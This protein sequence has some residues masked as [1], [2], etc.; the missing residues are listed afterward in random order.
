MVGSL[1]INTTPTPD[2][3][4]TPLGDE[5]ESEELES[6]SEEEEDSEKE[7]DGQ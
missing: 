3:H 4:F 6:S 7:D 5:I 2:D 1:S